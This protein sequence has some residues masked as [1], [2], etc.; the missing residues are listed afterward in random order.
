MN[1]P[2]KPNNLLD[3]AKLRA[4]AI[5]KEQGERYEEIVKQ[6]LDIII[7]ENMT[8]EELPLLVQLLTNRINRKIDLAHV[9]K[10]LNL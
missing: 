9:E 5:A 3:P 1:N 8:V 4:D 6:F 7:K 10:I 2:L